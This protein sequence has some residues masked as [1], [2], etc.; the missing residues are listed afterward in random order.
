MVDANIIL[1]ITDKPAVLRF[2]PNT[3][4]QLL[5]R[6]PKPWLIANLLGVQ[7]IG[8][9]YGPPG[10]GKTF[11]VI[12]LIFAACLGQP[13]AMYFTI[14]RPLAVAY[15]AGEGLSGLPSRFAAAAALYAIDDLDNFHF[16]D[17][18]PQLFYRE[19][20]PTLA[21]TIQQ[22]ITDWQSRQETEQ[23]GA[24]DLLIIDTLHSALGDAD[25]NSAK[26][27]GRVLQL[28]KLAAQ[29]L[30]CA[31]LLV[32]H[33]NK[34]GTGERGSSALRGAMDVMLSVTQTAGKFVLQCEKLKDGAAW[35]P[36]TFDLVA[37]GDSVRVGWDI[38]AAVASTTGKQQQDKQTIVSFL[39]AHAGVKYTA[40]DL[41]EAVGMGESKQI[42]KLLKTVVDE[43]SSIFCDRKEPTRD[44]SSH[45]PLIYWWETQTETIVN[46]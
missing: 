31:V 25:E 9:L 43:Y 24:L 33:T 19:P 41:A 30:D 22:F 5:R 21:D 42:F 35:K 20:A 7:D 34:A 45:N 29:A 39:E 26:D 38:P 37:K 8:M 3:L 46:D 12:D 11:V 40:R 28:L 2:T 18:V 23:E 36:R 17:L 10:S 4:A 32:H 15:C 44:A 13:F 14:E 1:P 6:P 27:M 16:F